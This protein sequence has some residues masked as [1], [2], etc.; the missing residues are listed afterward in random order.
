MAV[1]EV[2]LQPVEC[3]LEIPTFPQAT[4]TSVSEIDIVINNKTTI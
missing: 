4:T 3:T 2:L 1:S